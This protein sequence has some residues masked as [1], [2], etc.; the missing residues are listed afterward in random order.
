MQNV[1][2]EANRTRASVVSV[3][4]SPAVTNIDMSGMVYSPTYRGTVSGT[5][6]T[7]TLFWALSSLWRRETRG[8]S[9]PSEI[10]GHKAYRA[11]I[12]YGD[13]MLHYIFDDL[14]SHGG[15]WYFALHEMTKANPVPKEHYGRE[16][17]M[18]AD[19]LRWAKEN[20][21]LA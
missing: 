12:D 15:A 18:R 8:V 9:S 3:P 17:L 16:Q 13:E 4:I 19:W 10:V 1:I 20:N 11:I 7:K 2:V 21:Y 14:A 5:P 6:V